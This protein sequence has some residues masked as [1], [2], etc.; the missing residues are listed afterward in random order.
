[1]NSGPKGYYEDGFQRS[2]AR[3]KEQAAVSV[4]STNGGD[5]EITSNVKRG[6]ITAEEESNSGCEDEVIYDRKY[7]DYYDQFC[8]FALRGVKST[9][10]R[11]VLL[12]VS[13]TYNENCGAQRLYEMKTYTELLPPR[14]C[15][16]DNYFDEYVIPAVEGLLRIDDAEVE[17]ITFLLAPDELSHEWKRALNIA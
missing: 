9:L 11:R 4:T 8:E 17:H 6:Q 12:C 3:E 5:T 16:V 15:S 10:N 7:G 13:V 1:M 14:T 2:E